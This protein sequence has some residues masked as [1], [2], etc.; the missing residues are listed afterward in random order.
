MSVNPT[1]PV[2]PAIDP[3]LPM[4][5]YGDLLKGPDGLLIIHPTEY[6]T[7]HPN[8]LA[9]IT[10]ARI[11]QNQDVNANERVTINPNLGDT[12]YNYFLDALSSLA[13]YDDKGQVVAMAIGTID[14]KV[15]IVVSENTEVSGKLITHIEKLVGMLKNIS[16]ASGDKRTALQL[17][18][19]KATYLHS[20]N[21]LYKRFHRRRWLQEFDVEFAKKDPKADKNVLKCQVV[22]SALLT[23][24]TAIKA[25]RTEDHNEN[26]AN[27]NKKLNFNTAT[28]V[29]DEEWSKLIFMMSSAIPYV[30]HLLDNPKHCQTWADQLQGIIP[31]RPPCHVP[32]SSQPQYTDPRA[33]DCLDE[34]NDRNSPT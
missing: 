15:S 8:T 14:K 26:T 4:V 34:E 9:A 7:T 18:F 25:I 1:V 19:Y 21:Q 29:K 3:T 23:S 22:L 11:A 32:P 12:R 17:E 33:R 28:V 13:V 30:Q 10:T 6:P 31:Y 2:N 5:D 27:N 20:F 16:D 24:F